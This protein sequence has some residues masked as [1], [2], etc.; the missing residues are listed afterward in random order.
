MAN[1]RRNPLNKK[2]IKD[3]LPEEAPEHHIAEATDKDIEGRKLLD[4]PEF[5]TLLEDSDFQTRLDQA[6]MWAFCNHQPSIYETW[7]DLR[8]SVLIKFGQWFS[9]DIN[10]KD[11]TDLARVLMLIA[12]NLIIDDLRRQRA[13]GHVHKDVGLEQVDREGLSTP[14][15]EDLYQHVLFIELRS[16]L[17]DI[18]REIFDEYFIEGKTVRDIAETRNLSHVTIRRRIQRIIGEAR[19]L[20]DQESVLSK[21]SAKA[22]GLAPAKSKA[23][24]KTLDALL[25]V[26]GKTGEDR[27]EQMLLKEGL[28]SKIPPPITD[29]ALYQKRKPI[30]IRGKP[31]SETIIE[32]R[33]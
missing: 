24:R 19:Q 4:N 15:A 31:I 10:I 23:L 1:T 26:H 2:A 14:S 3:E 9:R 17:T 25:R 29:F 13:H 8:Q 18:E 32:E 5:L 21:D 20:V 27:L 33:R 7:Q 22:T 6:C 11:K 28:L 12:R 30:T 16:T